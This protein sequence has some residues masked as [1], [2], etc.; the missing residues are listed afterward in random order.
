M[1]AE[2]HFRR[3]LAIAEQAFPEGHPHLGVARAYH[4]LAIGALGRHEEAELGLLA[5]HRACVES[6]GPD[7]PR[8]RQIASE[9]ASFYDAWHR[10]EEAER[11]RTRSPE[12]A[13][14]APLEPDPAQ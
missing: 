8:S 10:P 2:D 7:N 11:W 9:I 1:E 12:P 5:A 6:L 3:A 14:R 4:A 13:A